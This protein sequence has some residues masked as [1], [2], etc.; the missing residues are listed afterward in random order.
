MPG[1]PAYLLKDLWP[2]QLTV[3]TGAITVLVQPH[4]TAMYRYPRLFPAAERSRVRWATQPPRSAPQRLF[5]LGRVLG[6][7]VV[8]DLAVAEGEEVVQV[9]RHRLARGA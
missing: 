5:G 3:T 2:G 7:P 4:Q 6:A 9:H 1:V 8:G